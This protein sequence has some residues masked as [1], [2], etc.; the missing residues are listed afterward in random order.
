MNDEHTILRAFR[1]EIIADGFDHI[2]IRSVFR[3]TVAQHQNGA[4]PLERFFQKA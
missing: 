2:T 1:L 4:A 3:Q